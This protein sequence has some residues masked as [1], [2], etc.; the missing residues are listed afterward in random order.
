M[1]PALRQ[2]AEQLLD[3]GEDAYHGRRSPDE[4]H[5]HLSRLQE[6]L[7]QVSPDAQTVTL[8]ALAQQPRVGWTAIDWAEWLADFPAP[9]LMNGPQ[10]QQDE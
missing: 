7:S 10:S 8:L 9:S 3:L 5:W 2:Y 4:V 6:L 1:S